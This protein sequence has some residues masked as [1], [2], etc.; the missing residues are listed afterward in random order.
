M[1][2]LSAESVVE[3]LRLAVNEYC[4]CSESGEEDLAGEPGCV[5]CG[6]WHAVVTRAAEGAGNGADKNDQA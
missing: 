2:K 3:R 6:I 5:A 4:E 1:D